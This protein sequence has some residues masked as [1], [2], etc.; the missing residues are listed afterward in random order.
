MRSNK[1]FVFSTSL[2]HF[3]INI[4]FHLFLSSG[5]SGGMGLFLNVALVMH[6]TFHN[7]VTCAFAAHK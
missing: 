2:F 7:S 3:I 4:F 1:T 5:Y 6:L